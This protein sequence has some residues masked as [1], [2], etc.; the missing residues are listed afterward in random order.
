MVNRIQI[1]A[2]IILVLLSYVRCNP[3]LD[4]PEFKEK[5][6][7]DGYIIKDE[8]PVVY[9]TKSLPF[10]YQLDSIDLYNSII[11]SAWVRIST[12]TSEEILT[13]KRDNNR[14][15]PFYY[16]GTKIKGKSGETYDLEIITRNK[17]YISTTTIPFSPEVKQ[18]TPYII[19]DQDKKYGVEISLIDNNENL[20]MYR[21]LYR[22]YNNSEQLYSFQ[23]NCFSDNQIN[24]NTELLKLNKG[25][26]GSLLSNN[27]EIQYFMEGDSIEVLICKID[28]SSYNFWYDFQKRSFNIISL[29]SSQSNIPGNI[30]GTLGI[31]SGY[32]AV[33]YR[34]NFN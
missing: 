15:I 14:P 25:T 27:E 34:I 17:K 18:V 11:K 1:I 29:G 16:T 28:L 9:I 10:N 19:E 30:E 31:W 2:T 20:D 5:V 23:L 32:G 24:I 21:L 4:T 6:I 12:D 7:I 13:L 26:N 33:K 3:E 8:P 22:E